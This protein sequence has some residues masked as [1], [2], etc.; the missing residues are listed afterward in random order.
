[1]VEFLALSSLQMMGLRRSLSWSERDNQPGP[2][3]EN[4]NLI[5]FP[6]SFNLLLYTCEHFLR[7]GK[8]DQFKLICNQHLCSTSQF[9]HQLRHGRPHFSQP[10]FFDPVEKLFDCRMDPV[11]SLPLPR[12]PDQPH[13]LAS[14]WESE[15]E[16]SQKVFVCF[17]SVFQFL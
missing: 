15:A 17:F 1:M 8:V 4:D 13:K 10:Q 5:P 6:V 3:T 12:S 16:Q 14:R 2:N 7:S 9:Q 11:V